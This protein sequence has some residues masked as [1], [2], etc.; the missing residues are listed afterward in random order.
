MNDAR[1]IAYFADDPTR[2]YQLI[3]WLEV[4]EILDD[5]HHVAVVTRDAD[6]AELLQ[7]RTRLRVHLAPSFSDLA[8]LYA[9]LDAAVVLYCNNSSMNFQSLLD[10]RMLHIHINHGESDKQSMASN[11]AKAYDRVFVAGDAAV[12]RYV[13]G[14]LEL[15]ASKLVRI[16]RPQLDLPRTPLLEP[17][18]RRTVM[19]A[20]TWEGDADYNDYTSIVALGE[21]IVRVILDVPDVRLVYKPHPKVTTSLT[22]SV[23]EAHLAILQLIDAADGAAGHTAVLSGDILAVMPGCDAMVTDVSSVGLD[24]LY[25]HTD[26]PILITDPVGDLAALRHQ[27]PISRCADVVDAD[28]VAHLTGLLAERLAHDEHHLARVAMRHHYF[29]DL[30]VGDSTGRFLTSVSELVALRDRLL[31]GGEDSAITA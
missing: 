10:S 4:L 11:N 24:W 23:A 19:Y 15:D 12:E 30:Q 20:P 2:T 27:A 3:Q 1:V 25:L 31:A 7:S 13:S 22:P 18:Q 26:K 8:E 5:L 6:S 29:D 16:G 9:E 14:L 28:N 17:S 21:R